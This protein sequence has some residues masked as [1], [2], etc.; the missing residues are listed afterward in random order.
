MNFWD[1]VIFFF[2]TYV[3]IAY[4]IVIITVI[5]DLFRDPKLN[6]GLKAVWFIFLIFV[7]FI[8]TFVYLIARGSGMRERQ[9]ASEQQAR[10]ATDDYIRS[11]SNGSA[12]S[13]SSAD[14]IAKAKTLLDSGAISQ[15]EYEGLKARALAGSS[16]PS[17]VTD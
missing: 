11:V 4:L 9:L 1:F 13:A 3:F 5:G 12:A 16:R 15:P 17:T 2:W 14:E 7:P 6:G 8:T 10:A